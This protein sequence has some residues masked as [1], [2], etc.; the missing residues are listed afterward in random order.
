[1]ESSVAFQ[2]FYGP[3]DCIH[4]IG[5]TILL[6]NAGQSTIA[7][8]RGA[9]DGPF[10]ESENAILLALMPH[11]KRA[12]LLHGELGSMRSQLATF[13]GHLDRYPHAFLLT[14]AE[15]RVLYANTAAREFVES[16]DGL[17]MEAGRISLLSSKQDKVFRETIGILASGRD[18]PVRWLEV[19]RPSSGKPYRLMLMPV[20]ASGVVPLGVSLPTVS[21]LI[22]DSESRA[23]PDMATLRELFSFT[24]AE[25]RIAGKLVLGRNLE[26]IADEAGISVETVRTHIKRVLS[27]TATDR[28]GELISL[29]LRSVPFRQ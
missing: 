28:Q 6:T 1:M 17:V 22:V 27:K 12:A 11:L 26:E 29:I 21:V 2:E 5:G 4:G 3:R 7:T 8:T 16:R 25:A 19:P 18:A 13:T 15:R 9:K 10:G 23:E 14:D 20:H 24:P